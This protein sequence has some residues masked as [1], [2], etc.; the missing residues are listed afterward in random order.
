MT[1]GKAAY[2]AVDDDLNFVATIDGS[3][4]YFQVEQVGT[5]PA[6]FGTKGDLMKY[7]YKL[8]VRDANLIDNDSCY[9]YTAEIT[10]ADGTKRPYYK[11]YTKA[12]AAANNAQEAIF[13]LKSDQ[14]DADYEYYTLIDTV[15]STVTPGTLVLN[16]AVRVAL[17]DGVQHMTSVNLANNVP[18]DIDA[19]ALVDASRDLYQNVDDLSGKTVKIYRERQGNS[20]ECLYENS[21]SGFNFLGIGTGT[22]FKPGENFTT[23]LYL[24][25]IG[26]EHMPQYMLGVA[27]DSVKNGKWCDRHGYNPTC[28]GEHFEPVDYEG[29]LY[30][31]FLVNLNDSTD[32]AYMLNNV[33][34]RLAFMEGAIKDGVFYQVNAGNGH[35]LASLSKEYGVIAPADFNDNT[36]LVPTTLTKDVHAN[37]LFSLRKI[38]DDG[39]DFLLET[40]LDNVSG[41][42]SFKG[43]WVKIENG[44]PVLAKSAQE[45]GGSHDGDEAKVEEL[46]K[47]AQVFKLKDAEGEVATDNETITSATAVTVIADNGSIRVLN[48]A[49]KVIKVTNVLG[50]ALAETVAAS[51]DVKINVPSGI[52]VVAVEG[53]AAVKAIVK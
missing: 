49:G 7:A 2:V 34:T 11:A 13:Y 19:F 51:D 45:V 17:G 40:N 38:T 53:E 36:K 25:A 21:T 4:T 8:K 46:V 24:H 35:T 15:G 28:S 23:A 16:D 39:E 30:G 1:G 26:G 31:R 42:G 6:T 29:Y 48:A 14:K 50:Q 22:D 33:Y 47:Q 43:A 32:N 9:V 12:Q 37:C 41:I 52:V 44:V 27:V 18:D 20:T 3:S 10:Q 5:A